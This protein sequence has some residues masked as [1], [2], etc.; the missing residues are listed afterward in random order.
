ME[1][2]NAPLLPN[3]PQP[4]SGISLIFFGDDG[5]RAGWR[6]L[7]YFLMVALFGFTI[8][9]IVSLIRGP[10]TNSRA[11]NPSGLPG[12]VI[13]MIGEAI[14]LVSVVVP[15][16]IMGYFEKRTLGDYGLPARGAFR[17]D[18]WA[19]AVWGIALISALVGCIALFHGY[20]FGSLALGN[21]GIFKY[22]LLWMAA[23]LLVGFFEEFSFRGYTQYTLASGIGF[24][25]A[26]V[27]LSLAFGA[28]HLTNSGEGIVGGLVVVW[29]ALFFC[30]TL[31]R[32]GSLWFAV[33][34]HATFDWGESFLYSVPDSG[35]K[36]ARHLS[37]SVLHGPVWL[38][39]GT[40]GPEASVFSFILIGISFVIFL[41][42]YKQRQPISATA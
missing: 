23:F 6:L 33:G 36:A 34:L 22:G 11:P 5:L 10:V 15:A 30:L 26:A 9:F 27:L 31:R 21:G 40:V 41:M 29:I 16:V 37:D 4:P 42:L 13:Q 17:K 7:V 19:G 35:M 24:W 20:E 39:G 2:N 28:I 12:P 25:P 38:T 18:F 3:E 1:S 32:T 14:L 8:L